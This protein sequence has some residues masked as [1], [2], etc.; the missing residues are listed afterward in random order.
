M[1]QNRWGWGEGVDILKKLSYFEIQLYRLFSN[2]GMQ[3]DCSSFWD[4]CLSH[5][6]MRGNVKLLIKLYITRFH[7][8]FQFFFSNC[9]MRRRG[10]VKWSVTKGKFSNDPKHDHRE[11]TRLCEFFVGLAWIREIMTNGR[12]CEAYLWQIDPPV[13]IAGS[14][15]LPGGGD[16]LCP[17]NRIIDFY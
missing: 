1:E 15:L 12:L 10:R 17:N 2:N 11:L 14:S 9:K 13:F 16:R 6:R 7:D 5:L 4:F 8:F 3:D